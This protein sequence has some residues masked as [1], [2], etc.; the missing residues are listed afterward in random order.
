MTPISKYFMIHLNLYA[1]NKI[2]EKRKTTVYIWDTT[3]TTKS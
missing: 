3:L 2:K 1:E